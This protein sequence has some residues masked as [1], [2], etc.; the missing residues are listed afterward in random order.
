MDTILK[1]IL[2]AIERIVAI[3]GSSSSN[4]KVSQPKS[5]VSIL[6]KHDVINKF[7]IS[8]ST[9]RRYVQT[10]LLRPMRM[11]GMDYYYPEDLNK[12]LERCRLK[13]KF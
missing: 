8:E 1:Q 13:G 11:G 10:G 3:L 2:N 12:A 5:E 6:M 7:K 9:Y 4:M